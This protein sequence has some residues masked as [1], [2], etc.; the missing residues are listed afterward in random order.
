MKDKK[1]LFSIDILHEVSSLLTSIIR[2]NQKVRHTKFNEQI[3]NLFFVL[4][5]TVKPQLGT[6]IFRFTFN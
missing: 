5:M 3:N 4:I 1:I 6:V 2:N